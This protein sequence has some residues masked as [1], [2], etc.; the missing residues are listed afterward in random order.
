M[1]A[2]AA[3]DWQHRGRGLEF[4]HTRALL[5]ADCAWAGPV[6]SKTRRAIACRIRCAGSVAAVAGA[7]PA[8]ARLWRR[9]VLFLPHDL[10]AGG[11]A[12]GGLLAGRMIA[13]VRRDRRAVG[14]CVLRR[15]G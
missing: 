5:R 2:A 11:L 1:T 6:Q 10:L 12:R 13:P 14:V 3:R 8:A 7:A 4:R 9:I 15:W